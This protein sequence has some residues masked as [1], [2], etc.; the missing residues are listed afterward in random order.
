MAKKRTNKI[1]KPQPKL[2]P[3]KFGLAGGIIWGVA[4]LVVTL[5]SVGNG[6]ATQFLTLIMD[7]YPGFSISFGGA[8]VGFI[9]GFLDGF[10]GMWLLIWLYNWLSK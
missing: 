5:I 7:V 4:L 6:Y 1:S 3:T 2:N 9:Y 10:I 8:I